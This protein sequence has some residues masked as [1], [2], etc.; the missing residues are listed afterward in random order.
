MELETLPNEPMEAFAERKK[1]DLRTH[2][3]VEQVKGRGASEAIKKS[4]LALR[5]VPS[6]WLE[7]L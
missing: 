7:V 2:E 3:A 5:L 1:K 6:R 4:T